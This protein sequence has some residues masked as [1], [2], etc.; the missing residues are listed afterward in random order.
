MGE[1]VVTVNEV[2]DGHT[3]LDI[4]CLD[5]LYLSGFVQKLQTPGGVVYFLHQHRGMPIASP[6]VFEQIGSRF[7]DGMRRFAETNHIPVVRFR[8]DDRKVEVM[9][10]YLDRAA[11]TG[12]SQ[13]AA[14]G[15]AQEF[16]PVWTARK[17][18]TDPAKPP[19]CSFTKQ[20]RRV[21]VFYVYV[22]DDDFGPAFIKLC[23]YFPYPIKVWVNGHEWAKRQA[24][25]A[26]IG[27]TALSN[28][29]ATCDQPQALQA[30]CDRLG[31]GTIRVF[32]ERWISRLP[33]PL[34]T[35]DRDAGYW[36]DLTMRQVETSRTIVLDAPRHARSFF[37]ALVADT[38][39]WAAPKASSSSS[40]A[41]RAAAKPPAPSRPPSTGTPTASP[42]T[43]STSTPASSST[44]RT[45]VPCASKPW[46][47]T[48]TTSAAS[49]CCPTS[50]TYR[51]RPVRSTSDC[52][53]LNGSARALSL[54]VQ[55]LRGSR[56][57]PSPTMAGGPQP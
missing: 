4:S 20:Q 8:R 17:R 51:P 5:R 12:R 36:W 11:R 54:R 50:T 39:T 48:P 32:F 52:W 57:P 10:P 43:C 33:L 42:S 38:S 1:R 22:W 13:V 47:T 55:P 24:A 26:G 19:Q 56:S 35:A 34:S 21:T 29:F 6:A 18:D 2:L 14:I 40:N 25:K 16:A 30:I 41:T 9:R 3:V 53:T 28:G 44:S 49:A 45:A 15:V 27:F 23:A 7:R 46:S 37:E 31:P